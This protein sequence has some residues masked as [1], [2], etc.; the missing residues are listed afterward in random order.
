[1]PDSLIS[2]RILQKVGTDKSL[3]YADSYFFFNI[4]YFL[5]RVFLARFLARST[6]RIY[7]TERGN[8]IV[9]S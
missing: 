3:V 1:M 5:Y 8:K 4:E 6:E 2:D 7:I 9:Y